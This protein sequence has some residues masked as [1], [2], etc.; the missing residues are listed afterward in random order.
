MRVIILEDEAP[1]ARRL[2]KLIHTYDSSIEI[3]AQFETVAEAVPWFR[4]HPEPNLVFADIQLG[5][6]LSFAL[7]NKVSVNAPIIFTTAYD[8][9]A[10]RAF[11]HHSL[12]YLLKPI[13]QDQLNES[14]DKY[15]R[16][17][18]S[19]SQPDFE[20]ISKD[21]Q[22][23]EFKQRFLVQYKDTLLPILT[24]DI[25]FFF[26]EHA[27]VCLVTQ[28]GK[29]HFVNYSLDELENLLDPNTF[30]RANRQYL[31]AF[32]SIEKLS[33][34]FH[35]KLLLQLK[36]NTDSPIIISKERA[37]KFKQWLNR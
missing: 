14:L 1:A 17:K 6:Q 28:D 2:Q 3:L 30:F 8:E 29:R 23:T 35:R 5:D 37:V 13:Q 24:S 22:Q 11:R 20:Q 32:T 27:T 18:R 10:L 4:N 33:Q 19:F 25:A 15:F 31:I 12:D 26:A 9:Y 36:S 7:F 34:H 21:L 16:L